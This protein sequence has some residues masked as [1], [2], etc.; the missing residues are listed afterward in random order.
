[1]TGRAVVTTRLSSDTM[2]SAIEVMAKVQAALDRVRVTALGLLCELVVTKLS[3]E[4]G[5]GALDRQTAPPWFE[6]PADR[7]SSR[8]LSDQ[9]SGVPPSWRAAATLSSIPSAKKWWI[10]SFDAPLSCLTA[11]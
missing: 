4:K 9:V 8:P 2:N 11:A 6:A 7:L 10:S 5:G 1:M 3:G